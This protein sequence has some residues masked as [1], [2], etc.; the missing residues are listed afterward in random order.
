[1]TEWFGELHSVALHSLRLSDFPLLQVQLFP[2]SI[3]GDVTSIPQ[4]GSLS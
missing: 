3:D 4:N 2:E 1:M